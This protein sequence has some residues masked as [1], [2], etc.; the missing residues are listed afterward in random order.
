MPR[1]NEYLQIQPG[2]DRLTDNT[3]FQQLRDLVRFSLDF[4]ANRFRLLSLQAL[5][6]RQAKEP[7]SRTFN[8]AVDSL[9]RNKAHIPSDV[10]REVRGN[11]LAGAKAAKI[12]EQDLDQRAVLL[13]PLATAGIT[14]VAMN[15]E[16]AREI[17]LLERTAEQLR[18]IATSSDLSRLLRIAESL[19][20]TRRRFRSL[21]ALFSPLTTAEDRNATARLLVHPV[22]WQ[23]VDAMAPLMPGVTFDLDGIPQGL[24]FP[25][26]SFA[27]WNA[28]LQ[29]LVSNAWNALLDSDRLAISFDGGRDNRLREWLLVS[30]TGVGLGVSL[31]ESAQLFYPFERR[32]KISPENQSIAM[33]G[34]GLGLAIVRM[35][36]QRR[37]A[38]TYFVPAKDG[39]TTTVEI[40]WRGAAE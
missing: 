17:R 4:Y 36:A 8:R 21:Q 2:R 32:L 33:G 6:T 9:D 5:E 35:I 28:M 22:V 30:D 27:E 37:S 11:I 25:L 12:A 19:D 40:S 29:N 34:Q 10:Y 15:H 16:F 18:E 1:P 24:R 39:F 26:G 31:E 7:P 38:R 13:A 23:V 14:A 20:A 3:A